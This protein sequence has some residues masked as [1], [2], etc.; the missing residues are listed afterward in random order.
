[1]QI[2]I[3]AAVVALNVLCGLFAANKGRRRWLWTAIA[4][5]VSP[6]LTWIILLLLKDIRSG[7]EV[8][9]IAKHSAPNRVLMAYAAGAFLIAVI[10]LVGVSKDVPQESR[11]ST[12]QGESSPPAP[13]TPAPSS[14][15]ST[16][17]PPEQSTPSAIARAKQIKPETL[18]RFPDSSIACL[19]KDALQEITTYGANGQAT[20]MQAMMLDKKNPD[21]QCIM[22]DPKMRYKVIS[23]EYNVPDMPEMGILEIVGERTTSKNGAWTFSWVAEP[24]KM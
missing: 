13:T 9:K 10:G 3:W 5:L 17:K 19:S 23:S 6:L 14:T 24:V 8:G 15:D 12:K 22:L 1:M 2:L 16:V 11:S 21:G 7:D 18:V 20:K 4:F